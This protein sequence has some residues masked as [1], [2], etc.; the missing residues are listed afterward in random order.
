MMKV[1]VQSTYPG[2]VDVGPACREKYVGPHVV[3]WLAVP[4]GVAENG[5]WIVTARTVRLL[6]DGSR[7]LPS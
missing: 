3:C 1:S 2:E 7:N 4:L 5:Y 6:P